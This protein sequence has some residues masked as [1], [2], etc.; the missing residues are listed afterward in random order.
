MPESTPI[1]RS[2]S[3]ITHDLDDE[4]TEEMRDLILA[5]LDVLL[6]GGAYVGNPKNLKRLPDRPTPNEPSEHP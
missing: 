5:W 6:N 3:T 1:R 2:E 4:Y